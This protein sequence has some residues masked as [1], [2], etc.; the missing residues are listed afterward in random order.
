M[1]SQD[2]MLRKQSQNKA[3]TKPIQSQYEPNQTQFYAKQ[4]QNKPNY[5]GKTP[6][7]LSREAFALT[8]ISSGT[9]ILCSIS[10]RDQRTFSRVIF[11]IFGQIARSVTQKNSFPGFCFFKVCIMPSS[12]ATIKLVAWLSFAKRSI[13]PV[14]SIF[15]AHSLTCSVHSG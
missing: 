13:C 6:S 2:Q 12:V 15:S 3:K 7:I 10:S 1:I 11:F 5:P 8:L 9:V 14:L 4:T